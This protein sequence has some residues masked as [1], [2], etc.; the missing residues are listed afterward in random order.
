[1]EAA[2]VPEVLVS[3]NNHIPHTLPPL[4]ILALIMDAFGRLQKH[5]ANERR[6]MTKAPVLPG[7]ARSAGAGRPRIP[8]G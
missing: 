8:P 6:I 3:V 4:K 7:E 5:S 1:V 2:W